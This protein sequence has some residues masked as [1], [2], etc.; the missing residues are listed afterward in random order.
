[1]M[2]RVLLAAIVARSSN[3]FLQSATRTAR[4][5]FAVCDD[6]ADNPKKLAICKEMVRLKTPMPCV[7]QTLDAEDAHRAYGP[8][9]LTSMLLTLSCAFVERRHRAMFQQNPRKGCQTMFAFAGLKVALGIL[10]IWIGPWCSP[11][12]DNDLCAHKGFPIICSFVVFLIALRWIYLG[13]MFYRKIGTGPPVV[14]V[15]LAH[16]VVC[17]ED[18]ESPQAPTLATWQSTAVWV[19]LLVL[20]LLGV[21]PKHFFYYCV[22]NG[23]G[24]LAVYFVVL[25]WAL[26]VALLCRPTSDARRPENDGGVDLDRG[27]PPVAVEVDRVVGPLDDLLERLRPRG[28]ARRPRNP[29]VKPRASPPPLYVLLLEDKLARRF[30][31]VFFSVALIS[32]IIPDLGHLPL[33]FLIFLVF[34]IFVVSVIFVVFLEI[35]G[36]C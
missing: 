32:N 34:L 36:I 24:E 35:V 1:M 25:F 4:R 33:I 17:D 18:E 11:G 27:Q 10:W 22:P 9:V 28:H 16:V 21:S 12:C 2:V 19:T 15:P 8:L 31:L 23:L 20:L 29:P 6:I 5:S 14:A 7:K 26:M 13:V 3:A 30:I